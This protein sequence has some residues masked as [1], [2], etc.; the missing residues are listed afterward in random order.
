[1]SRKD[2]Y[3]FDAP[4][5]KEKKERPQREKKESKKLFGD[6]SFLGGL[7]F[8][9]SSFFGNE[10][11]FGKEKKEK[12]YNEESPKRLKWWHILLIVLGSIIVVVGIVAAMLIGHI[13]NALADDEIVIP[14]VIDGTTTSIGTFS[15]DDAQKY[16]LCEYTE[17]FSGDITL[18]LKNA[19]EVLFDYKPYYI[20]V[21]DDGRVYYTY[22][23]EYTGESSPEQ[24]KQDLLSK[25]KQMFNFNDEQISHYDVHIYEPVSFTRVKISEVTLTDTEVTIKYAT[26][27]LDGEM[28]EEYTLTGT[29]TKEDNDFAF[30]YT[31]LP[32]DENLLR[33]AEN[34]LGTAKYEYYAQYGSWVNELTFGDDYKLTLVSPAEE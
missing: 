7:S 31:N 24:T 25:I 18:V 1:M 34:L 23:Y 12:P 2:E 17:Y 10:S 4:S 19:S 33:V 8:K 9:K 22:A 20:L 32:E 13:N 6:G 5:K 26:G 21:S 27:A 30:S 11:L 16:I 14:P 15:P 28:S 3:S 29:Y